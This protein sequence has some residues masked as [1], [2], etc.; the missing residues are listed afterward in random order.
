MGDLPPA[1][2]INT[3]GVQDLDREHL[4]N[5]VR[6]LFDNDPFGTWTI[7]V[8]EELQRQRYQNL[9]LRLPDAHAV[10][11]S[12]EFLDFTRKSSRDVFESC[13]NKVTKEQVE[14]RIMEASKALVSVGNHGSVVGLASETQ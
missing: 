10:L 14:D 13:G 11:T 5:K 3:H 1:Y 7:K 4:N 2:N 8:T 9:Q 12:S 6:Y